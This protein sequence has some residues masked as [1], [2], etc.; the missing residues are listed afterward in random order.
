MGVNAWLTC[1]CTSELWF[2]VKYTNL[3]NN[4]DVTIN[5]HYIQSEITW[6]SS[7]SSSFNSLIIL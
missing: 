7:Y 2:I 5:H 6:D 1:I 3:Y 4:F